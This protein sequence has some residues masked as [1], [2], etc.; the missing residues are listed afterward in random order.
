MITELLLI[1]AL[2]MLNA[3]FTASEI[4]LITLN[5]NRI[6]FMAEEGHRKAIKLKKILA[7]PGRFL[8]TL[9]IGITL[10]GFTASAFAANMFS[11]QL[12]SIL[13][14]L[15]FPLPF[16]EQGLKNLSILII[17]IILSYFILIL[18]EMVPKRIATKKAEAIAMTVIGPLTIFSYLMLP[19]V[20]ILSLSTHF[21]LRIAGIDPKQ[22]DERVT[23]EEIRMMVDVGEEKGTIE[24][25]EKKMI[26]NIFEFN[27]KSVDD[28]MTHRM[29][30]LG[31][32][33]E[34]TMEETVTLINAEKY[35][36][37]PVYDDTIDN[38]IGILFSK[39]MIQYLSD[40]TSA[41]GFSL[42]NLVRKPYFIPTSKHTD[43]LLRDFKK[44]KIHMAII[45]DEYGGTAGIVT[46]EDLLEEIVGD[47]SDEDD[48]EDPH[49]NIDMLDDYTY[50]VDGLASLED[51]DA[52]FNT[53]LP[54]EEFKTVTGFII[55]QL[56]NIPNEGE[57]PILEYNGLTFQVL[58]VDDK[59]I[60]HVKIT[61]YSSEIKEPDME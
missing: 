57:H 23:E 56:G 8:T 60:T 47:I 54:T 61:T 33:V 42:M 20:K 39:D 2:I 52:Y 29:D 16:S 24:I 28:I 19:F 31:L 45:I 59:R 26:N 18:G 30:I 44:N 11:D 36:R 12:V 40:T 32:P 6:K 22:E 48:E 7:E 34:A 21:F 15:K 55:G 1:V 5:D 35:S 3:F 4:A 49:K 13:K 25:D 58:A 27:D 9:K 17:T 41:D 53:D 38:I 37:I 10:A 14:R 43:D 51:V 50:L 46:L